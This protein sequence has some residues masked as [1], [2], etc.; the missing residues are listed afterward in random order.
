MPKTNNSKDVTSPNSGWGYYKLCFKKYVQFSGR[1]CRSEYWWFWITNFVIG[2]VLGFLSG[3]LQYSNPI[4]AGLFYW[5]SILFMFATLL[6]SLA[7]YCRRYHDIGRSA[8]FA[9]VPA[10]FFLIASVMGEATQAPVV[11]I[12][13]I[14]IGEL[15]FYFILPCLPSQK[16]PNKYGPQP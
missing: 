10:V 8:W 14:L 5:L 13:P 11:L 6:P 4:L 15:V 16:G 1:A 7:V 2:F 9:F 12:I 3:Y